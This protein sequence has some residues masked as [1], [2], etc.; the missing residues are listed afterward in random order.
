MKFERTTGV[1]SKIPT[2]SMAD[3]AFL[4]LIF[5]MA[6]TIFKL[7]EGLNVVLPRAETGQRIPRDK[8]AFV[9]VD[10][11]GNISINDQLITLDSIEPILIKRL[12]ENQA[13][14]V[15]LKVDAVL[16]YI[17][18]DEILTQ[19]KRAQAVNVAFTHEMEQGA[20]GS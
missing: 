10:G 2:A 18:M 7:E 19:L 13:L 8:V 17:I 12:Q 20:S 11:G 14:I 4:L 9:W 16:P 1:P 3:I 5:F 15:G 6:T